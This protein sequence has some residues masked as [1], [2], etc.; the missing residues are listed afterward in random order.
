VAVH[1][2]ERASG[3]HDHEDGSLRDHSQK[4][5]FLTSATPLLREAR[6]H[7]KSSLRF[8][9]MPPARTT[10]EDENPSLGGLGM[11]LAPLPFTAADAKDDYCKL[12]RNADHV[13]PL[14]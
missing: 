10:C 4:M 2:R 7:G 13:T 6:N 12:V 9:G 3:T 8:G 1:A 11:D 5:P 14:R